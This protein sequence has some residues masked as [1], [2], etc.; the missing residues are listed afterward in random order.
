MTEYINT[1]EDKIAKELNP[2]FNDQTVQ[3][4]FDNWRYISQEELVRPV[5]ENRFK[6]ID[7]IA[8]LPFMQFGDQSWTVSDFVT[9][10]EK[11]RPKYRRFV[12][13][14][15][16]LKE[17]AEGL[18]SRTVLLQKAREAGLED[19]QRVVLQE[20]LARQNYL[21]RRWADLA[22]DSITA[23][24]IDDSA[25]FHFY[26]Q[27]KDQFMDAPLV[28]ASEILVRTLTEANQLLKEIKEG[29]DFG[30]L[31]RT[32][33]IRTYAARRNGELGFAPPSAFGSASEQVVRARV[34]QILGPL[35]LDP[36]FAILKILA[37]K[38]SRQRTFEQS[39]DAVAILMLPERKQQAF[40]EA[41]NRLRSRA[42]IDLDIE[43]LGNVTVAS[44]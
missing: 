35:P 7:D 20:K 25:A 40:W 33:S 6:K 14:T 24:S 39:K 34:G 30:M 2:R 19:E 29:V 1:E 38:P 28:N 21:L 10:A 41:V 12:K 3:D 44:N 11:T 26:E 22:E 4:V 5:N 8:S 9:E 27:H 43:A 16:D 18:V 36:N 23:S 32:H 31:A 37:R 42:R 15:D 17:F 13:T